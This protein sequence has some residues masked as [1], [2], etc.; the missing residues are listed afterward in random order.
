MKAT[1]QKSITRAEKRLAELHDE[2]YRAGTKAAGLRCEA[3]DL[4]AKCDGLYRQLNALEDDA[5]LDEVS[6]L[7]IIEVLHITKSECESDDAV[8]AAY[9]EAGYAQWDEDRHGELPGMG[10]CMTNFATHGECPL[11]RGFTFVRFG[12]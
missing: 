4:M 1:I 7:R 5:P 8:V 6:K 10:E 2:I 12:S 9:E 3:K 11:G